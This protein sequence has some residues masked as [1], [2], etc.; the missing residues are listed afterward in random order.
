MDNSDLFFILPEGTQFPY[1]LTEEDKTK[2]EKA[3]FISLFASSVNI[4]VHRAN[5]YSGYSGQWTGSRTNNTI[6]SVVVSETTIS[7][8]VYDGISDATAIRYSVQTLTPEQQEQ[9]RKNISP[10]GYM[11]AL[12]ESAGAVYNEET[13]FYELYASEGGLTDITEDEMKIIYA[14]YNGEQ[15]IDFTRKFESNS[16]VRTCFEIGTNNVSVTFTSCFS[17]CTNIEVIAFRKSVSASVNGFGGVFYNCQKL[18]K[19]IGNILITQQSIFNSETFKNCYELQEVLLR[20]IRCDISLAESPK[21][22]Y[23]MLKY[24]VDNASK[25]S[26]QLTW[27][28]H[29]TT[30]SYLTGTAEPTEQV[31]GTTEEWQ[32]LVTAAQE[33][34]ISFVSA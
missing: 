4:V 10:G 27:T 33:K 20:D 23:K 25:A 31:G 24:W 28:V 9:V 15:S 7:A 29:P 21:V 11:R 17:R 2:L 26:K 16:K 18:R 3:V 6:W 34:Q 22:N 14:A 12:Y 5:I 19:V 8:P 32:T 30:Y 1:T 13:G